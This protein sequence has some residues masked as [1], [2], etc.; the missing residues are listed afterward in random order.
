MING[1]LGS[2]RGVLLILL[3]WQGKNNFIFFHLR[4]LSSVL[5]RFGVRRG[6]SYLSQSADDAAAVV[7]A[8]PLGLEE[9]V[10]GGGGSG[11]FGGGGL[12]GGGSRGETARRGGALNTRLERGTILRERRM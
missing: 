12:G 11:G 8:L 6:K 2:Q 7:V 9:R 3:T 4:Q 10:E 5:E 1:G